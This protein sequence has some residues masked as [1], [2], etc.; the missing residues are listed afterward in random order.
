MKGSLILVPT[1][2]DDKHPLNPVAKELLLKA[3]ENK[4]IN[5]LT[6]NSLFK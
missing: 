6:L 5:G 2:I 4:D 3:V 1:P